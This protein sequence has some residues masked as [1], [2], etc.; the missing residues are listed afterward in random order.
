MITVIVPVYK[1]EAYLDRCV[2]SIVDQTYR[3]LEVILVDDG[4]PDTCPVMCDSWGQK[5][6]RIKVIHKENG[7]LSDA[8][9]AGL[10][11][12][13]GEYI[14]FVDSDD[15]IAPEML[16]I[17]LSKMLET[18][19]DIVSC[20]AVRVWE[21]ETPS[22]RMIRINGNYVLNKVEAMQALIQSTCQIQTVWN[23]LYKRSLIQSITFEKGKIHEDEFWSWQ[24]F[25]AASR[26]STV[27]EALYYYFQRTNGIMG[28]GYSGFP[29][30]VV[31][32]RKQRHNYIVN[33]LP[34]LKDIDSE[35]LLGTCYY[36][37]IQ[38]L[39]HETGDQKKHY[40]EQL[41]EA[42]ALCEFSDDYLSGSTSI[43]R[44]RLILLK[45]HFELACRLAVLRGVK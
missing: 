19:S 30:L 27:E 11:A 36:Q 38:V 2:Q 8:R 44:L 26:V 23:K 25:A 21:D 12:A 31:E 29:M 41:K 33:E 24:A 28:S 40:L 43:K 9:N 20:D 37:G 39:R 18:D 1:V 16:D 7:G 10:R 35:S 22:R 32:A 13:Q 17:L 34:E 45:D 3:D 42:A 15:W 5:Y 4:S 14:A 6:R